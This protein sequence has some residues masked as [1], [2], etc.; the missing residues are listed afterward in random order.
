MKHAKEKGGR[1]GGFSAASN[2]LGENVSLGTRQKGFA[3]LAL[4][5]EFDHVAYRVDTR[6]PFSTYDALRSVTRH[7]SFSFSFSTSNHRIDHSL[8]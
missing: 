3:N 5:N 1:K 8:K 6:A 4:W 2:L 7:S